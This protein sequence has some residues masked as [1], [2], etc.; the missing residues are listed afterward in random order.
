MGWRGTLVL[1]EKIRN[2]LDEDRRGSI[3]TISIQFGTS[4]AMVHRIIHENLNMRKIFAKFVSC[5]VTD[6]QKER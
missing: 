1:I 5:V 6:E 2:F 4:V 3:T